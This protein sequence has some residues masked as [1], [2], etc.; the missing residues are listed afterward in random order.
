M[1]VVSTKL[2]GE[3]SISS[4]SGGLLDILFSDSDSDSE[5]KIIRVSDEGSKSQCAY[6]RL[7]GVPAYG[8]IDTAADITIVGGRLFKKIAT[9]ARLKKK[10]LKPPE[11]K[12]CD[13]HALSIDTKHLRLDGWIC[14]YRRLFPTLSNHG[15]TFNGLCGP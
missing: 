7:Q 5:V 1:S 11:K 10:N 15:G 12:P 13:T 14:F 6:V 8:I 4:Q 3:A 2:G 9:I